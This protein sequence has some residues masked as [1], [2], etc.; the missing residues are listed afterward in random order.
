MFRMT[1]SSE[2]SFIMKKIVF[3][4]LKMKTKY[5]RPDELR[6]DEQKDLQDL[7]HIWNHLTTRGSWQLQNTKAIEFACVS[8]F[9]NLTSLVPSHL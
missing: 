9:K 1:N 5:V 4:T 7:Q 6:L 8:L 2:K 3:R